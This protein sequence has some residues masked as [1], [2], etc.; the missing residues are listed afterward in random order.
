MSRIS[1]DEKRSRILGMGMFALVGLIAAAVGIYLL[2][3]RISDM[4][5]CTEQVPAVVVDL[6]KVVS[7]GSKKSVTYAPVFEYEYK[8]TTYHYT[9]PISSRPP[10]YERGERATLKIDPNAPNVAYVEDKTAIMFIIICL[11]FG[12]LF[13]GFGGVG[14]IR[15][16]SGK[17]SKD[18]LTQDKDTLE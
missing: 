3:G 11:G 18:T 5:R 4:K 14:I 12:V 1:L 17:K 16:L 10:D 8:G 9:S 2:A 6:E 13:I 15:T 7:R